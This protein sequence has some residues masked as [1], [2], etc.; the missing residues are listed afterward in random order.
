MRR[1]IMRVI[2]VRLD[3][4]FARMTVKISKGSEYVLLVDGR[5]WTVGIA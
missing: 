1:C 2:G 3:F 5:R 4:E